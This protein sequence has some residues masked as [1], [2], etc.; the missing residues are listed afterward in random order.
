ML[1]VGGGHDEPAGDVIVGDDGVEGDLV[2]LT[3]EL[4]QRRVGQQR[5]PGGLVV[6]LD[7]GVDGLDDELRAD[8]DVGVGRHVAVDRVQEVHAVEAVDD[9]RVERRVRKAG[10]QGVMRQDW[11][12]LPGSL[13]C[14]GVYFPNSSSLGLSWCEA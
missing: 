4:V 1:K 9:C 10:A 12:W 7:L 11:S 6:E 8:G 5:R 14:P 2:G 3:E 13:T